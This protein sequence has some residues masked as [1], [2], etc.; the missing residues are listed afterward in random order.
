M[1]KV[2]RIL[3]LFL[4]ILMP[5][6]LYGAP[7]YGPNMPDKGKWDVGTEVNIVFERKLEKAH[8]E[9]KGSQYFINLSYGFWDWFCFDGK[10]G[11]GN[12]KQQPEVG[13]EIRYNNDFAG[14]Y[15]FQTQERDPS[16]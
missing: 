8:G 5:G 10:A 2:T 9:F 6:L 15:G 14:G 4:L 13:Q 7:C 3:V 1:L 16:W 11:L 12:I